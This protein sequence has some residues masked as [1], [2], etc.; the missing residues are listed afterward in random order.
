MAS[1]NIWGPQ[2]SNKIIVLYT[3]NQALESIIN[4][5]PSRQ[6]DI[7]ILVR[8]LVLSCM[9]YNIQVLAKHVIGKL[10][11]VA[12]ALSRSQL[13]KCK[14][15]TPKSNPFPTELPWDIL[16]TNLPLD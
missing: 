9:K 12:D 15:L 2:L 10:N 13:Q 4:K 7:M 14:E 1:I 6:S 16:P 11:L 3:D 5:P 8:K